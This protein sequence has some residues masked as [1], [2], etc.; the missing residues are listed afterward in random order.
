MSRLLSSSIIKVLPARNEGIAVGTRWF[1][2]QRLHK[3]YGPFVRVAPTEIAI[4]DPKAVSKVHA[5]GTNFRK[6]QQP[7][8][9][10]NIFSISEPKAHRN[11]QRFYTKAFS[12]ETLENNTE[13]AV[14]DLVDMAISRMKIDA[15]GTKNH[16]TDVYEWCMLFGSDVAFQVIYGNASTHGLMAT[17]QSTD[18]VIMG[19]YLQRM[20][21]WS[22]FCFPIFLLGRFLAPVS[23]TL[24]NIF[25][26]EKRY[27]DFFEEGQRQR[28]VAAKTTFVQNSRY[29]KSDGIFKISEDTQL[30]DMDIAH[31][32]TTFLG[33]GGEPVGAS[34]I[35]L[36]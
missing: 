26:V 13:P 18:K 5:L 33:A 16:V 17:K 4:S 20:V 34:L 7:G 8:T 9:P 27:A 30:S 14:R 3:K 21:A 28:D 2:I 35:F 25:K 31:D 11:R 1:Y 22:Q 10:F 29:S 12:D 36:I 24:N 19:S 23:P 15:S 32:I 6:R